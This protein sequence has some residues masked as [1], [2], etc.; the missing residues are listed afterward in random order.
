VFVTNPHTSILSSLGYLQHTGRQNEICLLHDTVALGISLKQSI[1]GVHFITEE[2][3]DVNMDSLS[4]K[5]IP[6]KPLS[7]KWHVN[8]VATGCNQVLLLGCWRR[9]FLHY[10]IKTI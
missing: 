5:H 2:R 8:T 7:Y 3:G 6:H 1:A 4:P 9:I 10:Y